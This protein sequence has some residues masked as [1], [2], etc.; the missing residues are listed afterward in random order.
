MNYKIIAVCAFLGLML[1]GSVKAVAQEKIHIV[2]MK[3][4]LSGIAHQYHL[5][6]GDLMRYNG[7]NAKSKLQIGERIKI[8]AKNAVKKDAKKDVKEVV[9]DEVPTP[10]KLVKTNPVV[11]TENAKTHTVE[12]GESLFKIAKKYKVTVAKLR[13]WNNLTDYTLT[14][15]QDIFVSQPTDEDIKAMQP[16]KTT[17]VDDKPKPAVLPKIEVEQKPVIEKATTIVA[18]VDSI[19]EIKEE[20]KKEPVVVKTPVVEKQP[21]TK[22][23]VVMPAAK[24]SVPKTG[25]ATE[26]GFFA[27]QF[28][29]SQQEVTGTAGILK[30][31]SGWLDKKYYVL[32]NNVTPGTIIKITANNNTVYAKVLEALPDV[33]EDQG[34]TLR[35]SNAA[36]SVLNITENKFAVTVDY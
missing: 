8:P 28:V 27:S 35:L 15:G 5:T 29:S 21:E 31:S 11:T 13:A 18:K 20:V 25:T 3:E 9:E 32:M 7:L 17:V 14:V 1:V 22:P 34:L 33:K 10:V 26:Q 19:K 4:T 12:K 24:P 30:T 2:K 16:A 6:V 36:A 23:T